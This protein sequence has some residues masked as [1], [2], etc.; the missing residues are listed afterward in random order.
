M[1]GGPGS[2][3]M[4]A[5]FM[6]TG[7]LRVTQSDLSDMDSFEIAYRPDLSW[8]SIGDLLFI[9]HPVGTGWSYGDHSPT[10]LPE[11]SDEF[12]Q[13]LNHFYDEYPARRN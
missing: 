2:T 11:I 6:E 8:Q 13:F 5:L 10:S 4:N 3:S 1:N 12:I 9:D 7:P